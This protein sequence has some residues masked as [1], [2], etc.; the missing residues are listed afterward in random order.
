M[1]YGLRSDRRGRD[2]DWADE[3]VDEFKSKDM[4]KLSCRV[5]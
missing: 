5:T 3:K 1:I 2:L 4:L